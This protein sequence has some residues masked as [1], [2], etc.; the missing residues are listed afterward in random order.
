M[1]VEGYRVVRLTH[2]RIESEP[3][4]IADEIRHLLGQGDGRA[5][6]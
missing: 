2:R 1:Q 6:S 3:D 4:A 5:S